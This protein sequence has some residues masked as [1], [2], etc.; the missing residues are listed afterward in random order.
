MPDPR[1]HAIANALERDPGH[2][3]M[4]AGGDPDE[5][6]YACIRL[7]EVGTATGRRKVYRVVTWAPTSSGRRLVG[8]RARLVDACE[9]A[10]KHRQHEIS[11]SSAW[12][13]D[14][15]LATA[16]GD[17]TELTRRHPR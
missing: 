12:I 1:L 13:A 4:H 15:A 16:Y 14:H 11:T 8:Y 10:R 2:W 5:S 17:A 7:L 9:L 3:H 6:P